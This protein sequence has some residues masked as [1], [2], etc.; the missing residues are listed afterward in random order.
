MIQREIIFSEKIEQG[1]EMY[2]AAWNRTRKIT[3]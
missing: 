1:S 3:G 2:F